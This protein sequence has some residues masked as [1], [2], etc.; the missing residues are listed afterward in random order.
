M[1]MNFLE[2]NRI[3]SEMIRE[4][5]HCALTVKVEGILFDKKRQ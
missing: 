4:S 3:L 2:I 1:R 5:K